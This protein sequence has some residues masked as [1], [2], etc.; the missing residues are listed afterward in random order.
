MLLALVGVLVWLLV[1]RALGSVERIRSQV[2]QVRSSRHDQRVDVPPTGDEIAR[3]ATTMNAM[4]ARLETSDTAQRQFTSDASHELR[5]PLATLTATLEIAIADRSGRTW[6]D[7]QPVLL[8]QTD[9]MRRLVEDLLTLAK[10]DDAG[11]PIRR[12]E[13]D[14]DDLVETEVGQLRG[15]AQHRIEVRTEPVRVHCDGPRIAQVVRNLVDN[16]DRHA[17]S[18][19]WV[20][21]HTEQAAAMVTVDNDGPL[22]PAGDRVRVFERFVRLDDSRSRDGGN[23]GLGLAIVA[24]FVTAHGG[25]VE[26]TE[27]PEGRCRFR[28]TLPLEGASGSVSVLAQQAGGA[29]QV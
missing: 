19:V 18:R 2:E 22:V 20:S 16:A 21:V 14:L 28:F 5:S 24:E 11:V 6:A 23:S 15:A 4:L 17:H 25:A 26:A 27:S 9:R 8:A 29:S 12:S 13:Q 1:G 10:A 3:L 7:M